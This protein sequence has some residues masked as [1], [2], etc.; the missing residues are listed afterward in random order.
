MFYVWQKFGFDA[1]LLVMK[2]TRRCLCGV[3]AM[4]EGVVCNQLLVRNGPRST[5]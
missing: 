5:A 3:L 1:V 4:C 2:A